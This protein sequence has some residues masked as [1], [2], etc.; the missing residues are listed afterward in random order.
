MNRYQK[1][2]AIRQT[3]SLN[4]PSIGSWIQIPHSSIAEILGDAGYDWVAIDLEHGSI[5]APK[6][7][8]GFLTPG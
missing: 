3:L 6:I 5:S 4:K 8:S 7:V 1:T 2:N